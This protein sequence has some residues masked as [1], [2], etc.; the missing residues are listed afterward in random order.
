[1]IGGAGGSW[2]RRRY[3]ILKDPELNFDDCY[4]PEA[5]LEN[6]IVRLIIMKQVEQDQYHFFE[7]IPHI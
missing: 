7:Q 2:N 1:M 5:E 4:V 6:F 3:G